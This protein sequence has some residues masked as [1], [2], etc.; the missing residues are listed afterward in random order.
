MS[1]RIFE[2]TVEQTGGIIIQKYRKGNLPCPPSISPDNLREYVRISVHDHSKV[3]ENQLQ[4][5]YLVGHYQAVVGKGIPCEVLRHLY[6]GYSPPYESA[7]MRGFDS[8][9]SPLIRR[10]ILT[11]F[12]QNGIYTY[13]VNPQLLKS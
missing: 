1:Y 11:K 5:V 8:A 9:I 10:R 13:R 12:Y 2:E 3:R 7:R 4:L 6:E